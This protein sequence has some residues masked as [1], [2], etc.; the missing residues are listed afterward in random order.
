MFHKTMARGLLVV[1]LAVVPL[2][3]GGE[4]RASADTLID[5][6][7]NA[8]NGFYTAVTNDQ[9]LMMTWNQSAAYDSVDISALIGS[10]TGQPDQFMAYLTTAV[11][12]GATPSDV[13]ATATL[14]APAVAGVS[15]IS[16][17]PLFSNLTLD[18]GTYYITLATTDTS[19][20]LALAFGSDGGSPVLASTITDVEQGAATDGNVDATDPYASTFPISGINGGYEITGSPVVPEPS[21][22]V[23]LSA[24][25]IGLLGCFCRRWKP[26]GV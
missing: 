1:A 17:L 11:G 22:L 21:T 16:Y 14:T 19:S 25:A 7:P 9:Y 10:N 13:V 2:L 5:Y 3:L 8:G 15:S 6:G 18:A 24:G 26:I 23:L 4:R 20:G 12:T